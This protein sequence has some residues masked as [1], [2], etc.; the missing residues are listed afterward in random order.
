[1]PRRL[2][3]IDRETPLL[4]PPT[5]QD[6]VPQNDISRFIL[7]AVSVID[8]GVCHFNWRGTGSAQ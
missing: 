2:V 7:D 4:L 5:I 6:W 8:V 1:M 3:S